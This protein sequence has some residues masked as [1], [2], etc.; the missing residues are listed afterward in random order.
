LQQKRCRLRQQ[1][2]LLPGK[3]Q[4]LGLQQLPLLHLLQLLRLLN[5]QADHHQH[6]S[7]ARRMLLLLLLLQ[8][9]PVKSFLLQGSA[10]PT[11]YGRATCQKH[12]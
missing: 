2:L 8:V 6:H 4:G 5:C 9:L 3:R 12:E 11:S 1:R 10:D 7:Q